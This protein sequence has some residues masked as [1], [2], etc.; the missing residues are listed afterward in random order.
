MPGI[1][2]GKHNQDGR[3]N[4]REPDEPRLVFDLGSDPC[5]QDGE[6]RIDQSCDGEVH[7][8]L[9]QVLVKRLLL[10]GLFQISRELQSVFIDQCLFHQ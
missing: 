3:N 6:E 10:I 9:L 2:Q 4:D 7:P 5:V 8:K 1:G